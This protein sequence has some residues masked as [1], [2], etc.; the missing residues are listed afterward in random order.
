VNWIVFDYGEVISKRTTALPR[1]A[2]TFGVET[3]AFEPH[4]WARRDTY[5]RGGADLD[6]WS[7]IGD[8]LGVPVD[9]STSDD[10]TALDIEGWLHPEPESLELL[11]AL[12]EA[13]S[14]L[15]LL[16][17]APVS[18]ARV[19]ERQDWARHFRA[20][21]FSGDFG[22]AKPDAEIFAALVSRLDANP[23]DCLFFDDRQVNVDGALAAG[24]RAHRWL[25]ADPAWDRL[26]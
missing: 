16:S 5:D 11:A 14:A 15:A 26:A 2:A 19:A 10:L 23:G 8:A 7:S 13:G 17:N 4:Y 9:Q 22:C 1:L 12:D 20:T 18:F 3:T 25:G 6:Y 21:V 24:L